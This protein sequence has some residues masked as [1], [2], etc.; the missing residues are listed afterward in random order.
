VERKSAVLFCTDIASRG[1][2]FP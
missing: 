1:I 2:D